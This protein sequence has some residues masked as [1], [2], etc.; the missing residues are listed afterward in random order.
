MA[1]PFVVLAKLRAKMETPMPPLNHYRYSW[2]DQQ[3][4]AM[5]QL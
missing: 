1:V 3:K 4:A 2:V 5:K